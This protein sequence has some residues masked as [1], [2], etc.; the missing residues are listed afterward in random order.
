MVFSQIICNRAQENMRFFLSRIFGGML[1]CLTVLLTARFILVFSFVKE[2]Y[3]QLSLAE[4]FNF[5]V[6]SLRF[7]LK[8]TTIAYALPLLIAFTTFV[9]KSFVF[10]KGFIKYYNTLIFYVALVFSIINYFCNSIFYCSIV[11][12]YITFLN[13]KL[14]DVSIISNCQ[15]SITYIRSYC[16]IFSSHCY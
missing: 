7:D 11:N 15:S 4:Q 6:L 12:Y 2:Q 3:F 10:F 5:W 1:I 14:L 8:V 13:N 16:S 9:N